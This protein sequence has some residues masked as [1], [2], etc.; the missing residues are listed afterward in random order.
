MRTENVLFIFLPPISNTSLSPVGISP[1]HM[2]IFGLNQLQIEIFGKKKK[3][4]SVLNTDSIALTQLG[5]KVF[6][7]KFHVY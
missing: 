4:P 5:I 2:Q 1:L 3:P 7:S 6:E